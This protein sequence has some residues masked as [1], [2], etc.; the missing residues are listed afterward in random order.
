[1]TDLICI[2]CPKGCR[3]K[4]DE[5]NEYKVTGNSCEK[6]AIYGKNELK[7]PTRV[8]TSTVKINSK[9]YRRLPVKTN[10]EVPKSKVEDAVKL[11]DKITVQAPVKCGDIVFENIFDSGVDFVRAK[12]IKE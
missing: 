9:N 1:M 7:N 11:L 5:E 4:V 10:G 3:L 12:T 8:I 6:G 2:M